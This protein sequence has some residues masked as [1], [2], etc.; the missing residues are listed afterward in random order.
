MS[1]AAPPVFLDRDGTLIV[2]QHYLSDPEQVRLETGVVDGLTA[3]QQRGHALIVLSNQSGIGRGMF[4]ES[5]VQRVNARV[6]EILRGCG[7]EI[8]AW[9]ICAHAPEA[10]CACRKP[11]AG[12]ALAAPSAQRAFWSRPARARA[13]APGPVRTHARYSTACAARPTT[14]SRAACGRGQR[15]NRR[16][17]G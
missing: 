4:T 11:L 10:M 3:L 14:S 17:K 6:A 2:E 1:A 12:M 5:D 13:R 16:D 9:Y 15:F 7:I 8:L